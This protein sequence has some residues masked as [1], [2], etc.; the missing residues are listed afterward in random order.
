MHAT[1]RKHLFSLGFRTI[2]NAVFVK[3]TD[4]VMAKLMRVEPYVTYGYPNLKSI[5]EIIYNKRHAKMDNQITP[6]TAKFQHIQ[7]SISLIPN[8]T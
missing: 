8:G 3:P 1:T 7:L 2:F 6:P 5:K 4:G